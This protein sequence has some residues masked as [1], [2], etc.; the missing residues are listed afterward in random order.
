[1]GVTKFT[2]GLSLKEIAER[3]ASKKYVN[4]SVLDSYYLYSDGIHH[5]YEVILVDKGH[6]SFAA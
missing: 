4:L 2:P 5:W 6:P 1:M 3:R